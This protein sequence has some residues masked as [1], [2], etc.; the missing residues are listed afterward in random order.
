MSANRQISYRAFLL[1][2]RNLA[3]RALV[4]YGLEGARL[5]FQS[6]EGNGI[7]RVII[8]SDN[9]KSPSFQAGQYNLRLH[10]PGYMD[11]KFISSELEWLSALADSGIPVPRPFRNLNGDWLTTIESEYD[12]P[13][14][15][16]C[17]LITWI[18][19]RLPKNPQIYH[20]KAVG[21]VIGRMQSQ[22][23]DWRKPKGFS[24]PH[25]DWD[26]LYG[27]GFQYGFEPE[28]ARNSIPKGYHAA[29]T[30]AIEKV[31]EGMEQLGKTKKVYGLIH[32][33]LGV[34]GNIL[35]HKGE[36]RPIDF[37][38]CGFGYWLFDLGVALAHYFV[39]IEN[40]N[41]EMRDAL[42]EGYKETTPLP[43]IDLEYL[44]LFTVAR[45]AQLVYFYHGMSLLNPQHL[46]QA[47]V[48][49]SRYGNELKRIMKRL[50]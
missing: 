15:R 30:S 47:Q 29:F 48:E 36:A 4:E 39:E 14:S 40:P 6:I 5:K 32:A 22:S 31:R 3:K 49:M 10:Q 18:S 45:L 19:G 44:D 35:F 23:I 38:D 17:S 46:E 43:E 25:W 9:K 26:G 16:N 8:P 41:P 12:V 1:R 42:I 33:D 28:A 11:P 7:Y 34:D 21:N 2:L 37:D 20:M 27:E 50:H 24:R 13:C